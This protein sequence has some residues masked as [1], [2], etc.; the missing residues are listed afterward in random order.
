MTKILKEKGYKTAAFT[1]GGTMEPVLGFDQGFD[2]YTTSMYKL[3]KKNF[4]EMKIWLD[5]NRSKPFFLFWHNFEVHAPYLGTKFLHDVLSQTKANILRVGTE[6]IAKEHIKIPFPEGMLGQIRNQRK[7]LE[8][9]QIYLGLT[10]SPLI[11]LKDL[12]NIHEIFK[13]DFL[14]F[15]SRHRSE[16]ERKAF[17]THVTGN[18]TL[19]ADFGGN[20]RHLSKASALLVKA[21]FLSL[22]EQLNLPIFNEFSDFSLKNA[23]VW[24]IQNPSNGAIG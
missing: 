7:L 2:K 1:G 20:P 18:W 24:G 14:I 21:G 19:K 10:D 8:D 17:L 6:K 5:K 15:A 13:P 16:M 9:N 11:F 4:R 3:N 23:Q 22:K 12:K